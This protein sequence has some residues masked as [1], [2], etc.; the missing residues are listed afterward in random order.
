MSFTCRVGALSRSA[1]TALLWF[2]VVGCAASTGDV[3]G[4]VK[5]KG[6]PLKLG[7]VVFSP[8]SGSV[9]AVEIG[10]DGR[11][12]L[13]GVPVGT[14]RVGVWAIDPGMTKHFRD[15]SRDGKATRGG[16]E[17]GGKSPRSNPTKFHLIPEKYGDPSGSGLTFLV[18]SGANTFDIELPEK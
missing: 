8:E 1:F 12:S 7:Q 4:V 14:A 2:G 5:Y 9:M 13:A 10:P 3:S 18:K 16:E 15:V 6:Q 11:Y 17:G